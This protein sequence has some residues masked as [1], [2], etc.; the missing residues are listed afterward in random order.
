MTCFV[1]LQAVRVESSVN[2]IRILGKNYPGDP[3]KLAGYLQLPCG[4]CVGCRLDYSRCWCIRNVH[5]SQ[6]HEYNSFVTLTYNDQYLPTSGS[7]DYRHFTLFIKRLRSAIDRK[8]SDYAFLS[9]RVSNLRFYMCGEYGAQT[10]RPHYHALFFNLDFADKVKHSVRNGFTLY[11][12][13]TLSSFWTDPDTGESMGYAVVGSL[14]IKSCA[15]VS[16]YV[17]KKALDG[18]QPIYFNKET[19]EFLQLEKTNMSRRPG[20]AFE[21]FKEYS[22]SVYPDDKVVMGNGMIFKPPRYYDVQLEK[23]DPLVYESIKQSRTLFSESS[24][25]KANSTIDRL[26]VREKIQLKRLDQLPRIL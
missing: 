22:K 7:L 26:I 8:Y 11:T 4:K 3:T 14:T 5:E 9:N 10:F 24:K 20:I 16:R 23:V 25:A 17:V 6:L 15:Y 2:P 1:P 21:W 13:D 19:G 12:S 18:Y